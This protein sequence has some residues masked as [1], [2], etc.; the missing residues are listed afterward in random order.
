MTPRHHGYSCES[1]VHFNP[2]HNRALKLCALDLPQCIR[3]MRFEPVATPCPS[4]Q[5]LVPREESE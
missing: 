5:R 3:T 2:L 4:Y 1:C